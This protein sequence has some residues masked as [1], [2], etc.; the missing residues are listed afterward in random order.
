[1][2][3]QH[4][5]ADA[6]RPVQ[7][8]AGAN[9]LLAML[10][11]IRPHESRGPGLGAAR[12]RERLEIGEGAPHRGGA[13]REAVAQGHVDHGAAARFTG[14][15]YPRRVGTRNVFQRWREVHEIVQV[16]AA[17]LVA[18]GPAVAAAV[19][20]RDHE[21]PGLGVAMRHDQHLA[22]EALGPHEAAAVE[23]DDG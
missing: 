20:R 17:E 11:E 21:E 1:M 3:D 10:L 5:C 15:E 13:R 18:T 8:G 22:G 19:V 23:H 2:H 16:G 14:Q 6:L 12:C 9:D 4:R 7:R